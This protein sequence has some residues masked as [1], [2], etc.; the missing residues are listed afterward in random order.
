MEDAQFRACAGD[1]Q[2]FGRTPFEALE[3][4]LSR[5]PQELPSPIT[6]WPFNRGDNFFSAE[7]QARLQ[8]LKARQMSLTSDEQNELE[9]LVA[10]SF[11]ATFTRAQSLQ[12]VK[13]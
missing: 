3:A 9:A 13:A 4:L 7:Q 8:E 12:H 1:I 5:L 2:G 11:E 6:I 10:R